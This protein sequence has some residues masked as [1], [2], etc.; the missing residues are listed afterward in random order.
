MKTNTIIAILCAI[1]IMN[2]LA[3][4]N[5]TAKAVGG[6]ATI[7]LPKGEKLVTASW[8][9]GSNMWYLTRKAKPGETFET[10]T[11]REDSN[12]GVLSGT[13]IFVESAP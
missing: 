10:L 7:N 13:V 11:Y 6:T 1:I 8:K 2:A 3:S 5:W 9:E 12:L 4:C